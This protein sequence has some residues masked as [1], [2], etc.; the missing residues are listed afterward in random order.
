MAGLAAACLAGATCGAGVLPAAARESGPGALPVIAAN[1]AARSAV[2]LT[3]DSAGT[4]YAFYRGQDD[5]VYLRT[6]RNGSWSPPTS[7]GGTIIGVPAAAVAGSSVVIA[8]RGTDSAL[9]VRTLSNGAWG[10]WRSW[11]GTMS[12]SP[13]IAGTSS[14][15][16][17]AFTRGPGGALWAKTMSAS[18]VFT[19]W[20]GLGGQVITAPTAVASAPGSVE[21]YA[22]GTNHAVWRDARLGGTWSGWKSIGGGTYSAPAAA[23][24]PASN[25]VWVFVR[26]TDNALYATT[27]N[28]GVFGAW[29]KVGGVLIDGPAAAGTLAPGIDAAVRGTDNA[30]WATSYRAGRWSAFTR[31]WAPAGPATPAGSLLGTDWTRIPTA[32]KV[33]ALTFDAGANAAGLPS[34]ES[35]LRARNVR[36]T[37]FLTG[38]WVR[39]F[40]TQA[41]QIIQDGFLAGNHS[42]THPYF[43]QLTDAQ[44]SA[45]VQGAQQAIL[46]ANGADT[47]PLFRFPFGDV[48]SRVLADVNALGYVAVRWT[49]DSL[50]WEG[51]SGGQTVQS[52]TTRVLAAAQPGEI[53]LMHLGSNP[54]DGSTLDAAAL[55]GIISGLQARGYRFVTLQALTA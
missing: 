17:D 36:A 2:A 45:E 43:T 46:R 14:G 21:V 40:P 48:N 18:G 38:T 23:W 29:R 24:I 51:T 3:A 19:G 7:L 37:F 26:G 12:A 41:N 35:A 49:V 4:G 13:A 20:T 5:A 28:A 32:S 16:I 25:G 27:G 52:V 39:D 9:W 47:R 31:A 22:V 8:G 34:I 11:G 33:V 15:R 10:P 44:V 54:T 42:V 1:Q 50:G 55:P 6:V 53:V 30:V